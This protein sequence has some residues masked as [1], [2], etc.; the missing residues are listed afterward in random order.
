TVGIFG[1]ADGSWL[2]DALQ[3]SSDIDAIA[4]QV[5]IRFLDDVADVNTDAQLNSTLCRQTGIAFD[6]PCLQLHSTPNRVNAAPKLGQ[7]AIAGALHDPAT[8]NCYGRIDEVASQ[9]TDACERAI[10][11]ARRQAAEADDVRHQDCRE[12]ARFSHCL[13]LPENL[14]QLRAESPAV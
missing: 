6:H 3:T 7:H 13:P 8:M 4:H 1:Q 2:R 5:A 9:R 14:S 12:L 10:L 11:L